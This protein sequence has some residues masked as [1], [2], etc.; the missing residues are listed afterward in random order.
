ASYYLGVNLD[1]ADAS[2]FDLDGRLDLVGTDSS[3]GQVRLLRGNGDGTFQVPLSF[4]AGPNPY[5]LAVGDFNTDGYPDVVVVNRTSGG[6]SVLLN[7][8]NW[9]VA[10]GPGSPPPP[11][12]EHRP[13]AMVPLGGTQ[14]LSRH[15][16]LRSVERRE[17]DGH[18]AVGRGSQKGQVLPS[19]ATLGEYF[20]QLQHSARL[21]S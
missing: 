12:D 2:D 17:A 1:L 4:G 8:A 10:P 5:P 11:A 18:T 21:L 7:D 15:P 19:K 16:P 20:A 14:D 3:T 6:V 9:P 13:A